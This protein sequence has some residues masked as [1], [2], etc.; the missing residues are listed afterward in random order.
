MKELLTGVSRCLRINIPDEITSFNI[1]SETKYMIIKNAGATNDMTFN[2][3]DDAE[4]DFWT[5]KPQTQSPVMVVK[6]GSL[7]HTD[8]IG[9]S[10][11]CE[12]LLWG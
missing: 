3:P 1:P 7:V 2:F 12:V 9:G 4:T 10:T 8:G 11:T 6:P 5:L